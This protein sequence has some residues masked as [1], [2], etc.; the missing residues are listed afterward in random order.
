MAKGF[1][2]NL[3]AHGHINPTLPLT[4]ELV[5]RGEEIVY[6]TGESERRKI[7]G[8]GAA[9]RV[10]PYDLRDFSKSPRSPE[11]DFLL[12]DCALKCLP[13][14]I[15]TA[16][17]EKPDYILYDFV[18]LWGKILAEQLCIPAIAVYPNPVPVR[19][20]LP[21]AFVFTLIDVLLP[22]GRRV[23]RMRREIATRFQRAPESLVEFLTDP[24]RDLAI[25]L[26]SER[27]QPRREDLGPAFRFVGP[28]YP[29]LPDAPAFPFQL[30]EGRP[31]IY[32]S[33]GT[34]YGNN[35]RFFHRCIEAFRDVDC[36]IV[37][38]TGNGVAPA[39][40][41]NLPPQFILRGFVPQWEILERA[42][43]FITH[44][45]MNSI[46]AGLYHGVPMIVAPQGLGTDQDGNARVVESL[47]VGQRVNGHFFR[48]ASLRAHA[49]RLMSDKSVR[50]RMDALRSEYR[51]SEGPRRAADEI[52]RF[53]QKAS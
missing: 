1:F 46:H 5:R 31:V 38:S 20:M 26:T 14:L 4:Q 28:C 41:R 51:H 47:G 53:T 21:P 24:R 42:N 19:A 39:V 44:G 3:P 43:L 6:F 25:V 40:F 37:V 45:G 16:R 29:V 15:E 8:T 10:L 36:R 18:S 48:P 22:L 33:L 32:V 7:E 9:F 17:R 30:L 12:F 49:I 13:T 52:L 27:F 35:P 34:V 11:V 50:S 2:F 23:T